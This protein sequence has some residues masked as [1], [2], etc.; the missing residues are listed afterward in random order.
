ML[1]VIITGAVVSKGF[2]DEPAIKFSESGKAVWFRIGKKVF[3]S[4]ADG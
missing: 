1:E 2:N 3:D 4:R